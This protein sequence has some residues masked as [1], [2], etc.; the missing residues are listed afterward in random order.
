[1]HIYL[2]QFMIPQTADELGILIWEDFI[3]ACAL[4]P[5]TPEFLGNVVEEVKTQVKRLQHHPS[6]AMWA[7]NN[8]NEGALRDN[9]Y[10][11]ETNFETYKAD[12][13]KLYVD[14]VIG[15]VS[16]LDPSRQ[17]ISSSPTNG[18]QTE[19]EGWVAQNPGS[20]L[21]GDSN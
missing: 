4:Y 16:L 19:L 9:W 2:I 11:S 15:N 14:T 17:C 18:I 1:M 10:G 20:S 12:Y 13:I 3:F 8:E 6:L 5:A 21:Y 7:T